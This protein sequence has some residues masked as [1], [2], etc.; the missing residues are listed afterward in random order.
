MEPGIFPDPK[1]EHKPEG[2]PHTESRNN[3]DREQRNLAAIDDADSM[4]PEDAARDFDGAQTGQGRSF[5]KH[6]SEMDKH[7]TV[8][9]TAADVGPNSTRTPHSDNQGI[10]NHSADI[11]DEGQQKVVSRRP[12]S[13][14]GVS[15]GHKA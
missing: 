15:Q 6:P 11:E 9:F 1:S 12:D 14:A 13:Q 7:N 4:S 10:T 2:T 8:P 5:V 3:V